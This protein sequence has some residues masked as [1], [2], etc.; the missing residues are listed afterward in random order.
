MIWNTLSHSFRTTNSAL[1]TSLWSRSW[2]FGLIHNIDNKWLLVMHGAGRCHLANLIARYQY[3]CRSILK[4][5]NDS[6]KRYA[7]RRYAWARPM[8]SC[9]VCL[10]LRL[11]V[12]LSLTFVYCDKMSNYIHKRFSTP[13]SHTTL[14]FP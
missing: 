12:L 13:A 10:S 8:P 5:H 11:S 4:F 7:A 9:S 6:C 2:H 3:R 14:V 1:V